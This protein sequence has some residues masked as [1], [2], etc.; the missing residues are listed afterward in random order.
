MDVDFSSAT[1]WWADRLPLLI[2]GRAPPRLISPTLGI[3]M[4][5]GEATWLHFDG[6]YNLAFLHNDAYDRNS[7]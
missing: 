1:A 3:G 4:T 2:S 5:F 7:S 6:Y